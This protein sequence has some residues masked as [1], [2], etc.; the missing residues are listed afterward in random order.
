MQT[1]GHARN[2]LEMLYSK[3]IL[4]SLERTSLTNHNHLLQLN[5]SKTN[6]SAMSIQTLLS[7]TVQILNKAIL[8]F[9][10]TLTNQ[11]YTPVVTVVPDTLELTL[12]RVTP[13]SLSRVLLFSLFQVN[14]SLFPGLLSQPLICG[15][16]KIPTS[17]PLVYFLYRSLRIYK[18]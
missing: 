2:V 17:F 10:S 12:S 18:L 8:K 7:V 4:V 3:Q 9:T 13:L 16:K 11:K 14:P 15:K 5:L 1:L 6:P